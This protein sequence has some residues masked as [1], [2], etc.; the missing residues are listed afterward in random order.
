M[1]GTRSEMFGQ[2]RGVADLADIIASIGEDN[3]DNKSV[4]SRSGSENDSEYTMEDEVEASADTQRVCRFV[5][6][7][8]W[9]CF[10]D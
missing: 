6:T 4:R 10:T 1:L 2:I 8:I 9:Q 3:D 5:I 7:V